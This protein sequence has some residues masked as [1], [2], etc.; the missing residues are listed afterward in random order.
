MVC[1]EKYGLGG[2]FLD[3]VSYSFLRG[4]GRM[5]SLAIKWKPL[6][7]YL[8]FVLAAL[9]NRCLFWW[10]SHRLNTPV[11]EYSAV[12]IKGIQIHYHHYLLLIPSALS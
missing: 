2:E 1:T 7:P 6:N 4:H 3:M 10:K 11:S 12:N 5:I 8:L 9:N